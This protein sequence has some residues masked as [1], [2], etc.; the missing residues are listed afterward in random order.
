MSYPNQP[1]NDGDVDIVWEW[2]EDD[3]VSLGEHC[4]MNLWRGHNGKLWMA[5]YPVRSGKTDTRYPLATYKVEL[6]DN[7]S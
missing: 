4:D 2:P 6:F 5:M 7:G 3:W 1:H